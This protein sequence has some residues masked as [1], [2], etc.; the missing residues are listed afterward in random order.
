MSAVT[1]LLLMYLHEE[2][3]FWVL[4]AL[5]SAPAYGMNDL[6]VPGFPKLMLM[7]KVLEQL[8]NE[9]L[10]DLF[11]HFRQLDLIPSMYAT[12]WF[13]MIFIN[14]LPFYVVLRIW[15]V[16]ITYGFH[17]LF[18]SA[19]AL[20][21]L[22]RPQLLGKNFEQVMHH[23]NELP[24]AEMDADLFIRNAVKYFKS[25]VNAARIAELEDFCSRH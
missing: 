12:R 15:D 25:G 10:P 2:D 20:M 11:A 13:L 5:M 1:G 3:T 14:Q 16:F 9:H 22:L 23:L 7:F 21:R 6:F 17:M 8:M 18:C 19:L 24:V 4:H